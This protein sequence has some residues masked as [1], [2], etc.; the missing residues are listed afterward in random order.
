MN[1]A[2]FLM[3]HLYLGVMSAARDVR[4]YNRMAPSEAQSQIVSRK[5]LDVASKHI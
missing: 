4:T 3:L 5:N 1:N 2:N